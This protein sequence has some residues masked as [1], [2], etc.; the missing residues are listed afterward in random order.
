MKYRRNIREIEEYGYC[1]EYKIKRCVNK[2]LIANQ[3]VV[4][5]IDLMYLKYKK[6]HIFVK[7][8]NRT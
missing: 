7:V 2:G 8:L 3:C 6:V 5:I 4:L 1:D